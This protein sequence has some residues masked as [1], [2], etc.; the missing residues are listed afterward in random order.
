MLEFLRF[1]SCY[2]GY[3]IFLALIFILAMSTL[4]NMCAPMI[5]QIF[6]NIGIEKQCNEIKEVNNKK[7]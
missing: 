5:V 1:V 3:P 6:V 2:F 4:L 7:H